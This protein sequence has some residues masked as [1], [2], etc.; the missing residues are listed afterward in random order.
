MWLDLVV[1]QS[2]PTLGDSMSFCDSVI[3]RFYGSVIV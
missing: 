1:L 3:S 2:F